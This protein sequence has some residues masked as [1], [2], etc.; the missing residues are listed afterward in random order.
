MNGRRWRRWLVPGL[1]VLGGVV[2]LRVYGVGPG[3]STRAQLQ[4]LALDASSRFAADAL[5]KRA[6][7]TADGPVLFPLI[8]AVVN[9]GTRAA[10]PDSLFLS[11][12]TWIRL[13]DADGL[14]RPAQDEGGTLVRYGL[15][16]QGESFEPGA[17]PLVPGGID[18]LWVAPELPAVT[19]NVRWDGVIEF[20]AA[21]PWDMERLAT[22]DAF[23]SLQS[24]ESRHTG[25]L[26]LRLDPDLIRTRAGDWQAG[27]VSVRRPSVALPNL[28]RMALEGIREGVCGAPELN[29]PYRSVVWRTG[30]SLSGRFIG[31]QQDGAPR[32]LLY[33]INGDRR[34]DFE[35]WDGDRDGQFESGR[36]AS[37][38]IPA[39]LLPRP[40]P[41]PQDTTRTTDA[42]ADTMTQ[43]SST[44]PARPDTA[45]APVTPPDT[46][47]R[48]RTARDTMSR[49][50]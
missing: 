47:Q 22:I 48:A 36:T 1:V 26:R 12:P 45:I 2:A 11:V 27:P 3:S 9:T 21:P 19:C 35:A 46:G 31:I 5:L 14:P 49:R 39:F 30:D 6:D 7:P 17:L 32:R 4:L 23:F 29:V 16:L 25:V 34:I 10:A 8:F 38:P 20:V 40:T 50:Q 15:A 18:R 41:A 13:V 28:G 44:I 43:D 42:A 37:W 24:G 33:D